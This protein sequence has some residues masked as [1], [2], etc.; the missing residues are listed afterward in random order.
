MK[1]LSN[2]SLFFTSSMVPMLTLHNVLGCLTWTEGKQVLVTKLT[3]A[4]AFVSLVKDRPPNFN[5]NFL[6]FINFSSILIVTHSETL[7]I[8]LKTPLHAH[9]ASYL[10]YEH[11]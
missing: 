7:S 11:I 3:T 1:K 4:Y 2:S 9:T 10:I 5:V 6:K 8:G